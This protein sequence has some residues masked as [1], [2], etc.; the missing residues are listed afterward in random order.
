MGL[1]L[2]NCPTHKRWVY[3]FPTHMHKIET[4]RTIKIKNPKNNIK[5]TENKKKEKHQKYAKKT[6]IEKTK[7][8]LDKH[9]FKNTKKLF[10]NPF[11][12]TRKKKQEIFFK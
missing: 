6:K 11:R 8:K 12:I 9:K 1:C 10:K 4:K 7:K 2:N 3:L 5:V